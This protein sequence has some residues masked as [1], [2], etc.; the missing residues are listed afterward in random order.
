MANILNCTSYA[1]NWTAVATMLKKAANLLLW[2]NSTSLFRDN[3]TTSLY[4][5]DGNSWAVVSNIT[6]S[7]AQKTA[8]T[9]ALRSRW[10]PYGAPAPEANTTPETISPFISYFEL[11]AHYSAG[12][13]TA[14]LE[15]TRLQWG[16][17]LD[18][19]RMTNSTF[20]EG[21]SVDG[22]LHYAY[23]NDAR[24]SHAHGWST[25]PTSL[26][27]FQTAGLRPVSAGSREW[28]VAPRLGGLENVEAGYIAPLGTFSIKAEGN[29]SSDMV[30]AL[31]FSAPEGT[32]GSVSVP[33]VSGSLED[34]KG[35]VIALVDGEASGVP[36][37]DWKLI[38][39]P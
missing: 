5:Q 39:S 27:T 29:K 35:N 26:L 25:G 34:E 2:D 33:G 9:D 36:G 20:I 12:N 23:T 14:A 18:D 8:I 6:N 10:G 16:F 31:S 37:G 15:L 30:T 38:T 1:A 11:L 17:M 24:V 7:A 32:I 21:F 13:A 28:A 4:P 22:S 3:E 19:P